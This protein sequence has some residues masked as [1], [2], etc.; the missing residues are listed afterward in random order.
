MIESFSIFLQDFT[1]RKS[2]APVLLVARGSLEDE[3]RCNSR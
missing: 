3:S 2:S 1:G